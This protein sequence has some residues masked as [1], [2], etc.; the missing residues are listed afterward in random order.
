MLLQFVQTY[1][2]LNWAFFYFFIFVGLVTTRA[3]P[4]GI[5]RDIYS[6]LVQLKPEYH[7]SLEF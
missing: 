3:L 6:G 5:P 1:T 7:I 2:L 4:T